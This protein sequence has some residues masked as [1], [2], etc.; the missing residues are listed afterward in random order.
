M[1]LQDRIAELQERG[2]CVLRA[3]LPTPLIDACR[4][5]FWPTLLAFLERH[6]GDS[7]RGPNRYFLPMQFERPCYAPEF[8]FDADVLGIVRG[9]MDDRVVAD[10]WGCD[11]PVKGSDYQQFHAD[12]QRPLFA[13]VP[14]L[15]LPAYMLNVSF[16]LMRITP[17]DGPVEIAPGTHRMQR[18]E[19][20]RLI[21]SGEVKS[22]KVSLEIGDVLIRHPW[23]LHRGTPNTTDVPRPLA[24]VRYVRR[25]YSDNSREVNSI[26]PDVWHSLN[27]NQQSAMR[28]PRT[29]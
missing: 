5:V 3:H 17:A 8:F 9:V 13:E 21:E 22:Q 6:Q 7:N 4:K 20:R 14:D 11:V 16:G 10:Q 24:T 27:S 15:M 29:E 18:N 2:F 1:N 19:A 12:Y 23:C 25:W 26:P 28:F